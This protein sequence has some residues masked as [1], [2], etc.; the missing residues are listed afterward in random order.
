MLIVTSI[1]TNY[2]YT[3]NYIEYKRGG[4]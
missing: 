4:T 3:Q 2:F 1:L